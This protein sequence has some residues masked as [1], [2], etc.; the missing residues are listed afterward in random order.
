MT[1]TGQT[2]ITAFVHDS[3]N[4][5]RTALLLS[6]LGWRVGGYTVTI[7]LVATTLVLAQGAQVDESKVQELV[8]VDQQNPKASDAN[9]GNRTAP[10]KTIAQAL[11][12]GEAANVRNTGVKVLIAPG[13]YRET[14]VL[15]HT[16]TQTDAPIVLE[17]TEKGKV[18][19]SGSDVW[20]DWQKVG[21]DNTYTHP[22][23]YKW[24]MAP[25]P[26]GWEGNVKLQPVVRRREIVFVDSKVI[27][28]V[29]SPL[30]MAEG[31]FCVS[32]EKEEIRVWLPPGVTPRTA[33]TEVAIR[34]GL[35]KASGRK[36]VVLRGLVFQ[37]D[38]TP[39]QGE[40]VNF[41]DCSNVLIEDCR[42][43]W[44]NWAGLGF[45]DCH[46][47]TVR[48]STA[49][50]NGAMGMTGGRVKGLL[51]E[52]TETSY[53]NWRGAWGEFTG[54]S[55]AGAKQL[56]I[57]DAV[58]RRHK[59]VGNK[60]GGFWFD[61]D[62]VNVVVEDAFWSEN[63]TRGI[64][65]E[66]SEGPVTV[67]NSVICNNH[68][69]GIL[70]TN[71]KKVT[72]DGN[73][74]YGNAAGQIQV[75]GQSDRPVVNW[76]TK[77]K[78]K[79]NLEDWVLRNNVVVG[80]DSR[81]SLVDI[82]GAGV[83]RFL[84]SLQASRNLWYNAKKNDAFRVSGLNLGFDRW[85]VVAAQDLNSM[86]ADPRLRAP[87]QHDFTVLAESPLKERDNWAK[88][89]VEHS[90]LE[91]LKETLLQ[92]VQKNWNAPY[93]LA[94]QAQTQQWMEID[95]RAS[96]NR[97]LVGQDGWI[98]EHPLDN[99][100]AG[101]KRIHAVPYRII[102][103]ADN[104]G[105]V[106]IAL[107]S[108]KVYETHGQSLPSEVVIPVGQKAGAVYF[109][110]GCAYVSHKKSCEYQMV[111][112]DG[113]RETIEIVPLGAGSEHADV[114][115]QLQQESNIQD[116]WPTMPQFDNDNARNVVILN[117]QDPLK[118]VRYIYTLQWLNPQPTKTIK[119][120]RLISNPKEETSLMVFGITA[121]AAPETK[122]DLQG[123]R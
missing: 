81:Q 38:G 8:Y 108:A 66:A 31:D 16:A 55:V 113:T 5:S 35:L 73:T 62:C 118:T 114:L 121:L 74:L 99:L 69:V 41:S 25:Y 23:P 14:V 122:A 103:A 19:I 77:E 95:L 67:R 15:S 71:S 9:D 75:T 59:S 52:D 80:T 68:G 104:N 37:H 21:S 10:L 33:T 30:E 48:R 54:W 29:V 90:G 28:Q 46:E 115:K 91:A 110:H 6:H 88:R 83:E 101:E 65:I 119:E 26:A 87:E 60:T 3:V 116:W 20:T 47:M 82:S 39:L 61:F 100:T 106:A 89:I 96:A 18:T 17:A 78:M 98:G 92:D 40:A 72:L 86:F 56:R 51:Y 120:L 7:L 49:N 85:Q 44:N 105:L 11:R 12:L 109:L 70:S 4:R 43:D 93:P 112:E 117:P 50:H 107:R 111:Y 13:I 2:R 123:V 53:N 32:E 36:N 94:A 24:G 64:F 97:P 34:A 27:H 76:E 22:W 79:L 1:V 45:N 57:H 102:D 58:Y 42:F 63:Q 84:T